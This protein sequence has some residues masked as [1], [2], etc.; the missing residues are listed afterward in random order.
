M[1]VLE[2]DNYQ[3]EGLWDKWLTLL[4][5]EYTKEMI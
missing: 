2:A 3:T 1:S 5:M 4:Q